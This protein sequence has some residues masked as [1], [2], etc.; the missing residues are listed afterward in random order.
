MTAPA[1][2]A[3]EPLSHIQRRGVETSVAVTLDTPEQ[4]AYQ[5]SVPV[6]DFDAVS[7]PRARCARV[8]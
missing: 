7:G 4:I 3:L 6:P 2:E 5:H 1:R 8:G